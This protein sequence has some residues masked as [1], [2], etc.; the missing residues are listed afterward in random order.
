MQKWMWKQHIHCYYTGHFS[1][2]KCSLKLD[3]LLTCHLHNTAPT[4]LW[5]TIQVIK[6]YQCSYSQRTKLSQA[7]SAGLAASY[8]S[9]AHPSDCLSS[10]RCQRSTVCR[11]VKSCKLLKLCWVHGSRFPASNECWVPGTNGTAM[12]DRCTS[13]HK[14]DP[15]KKDKGLPCWKNMNVYNLPVSY[16]LQDYCVS[17]WNFER[18]ACTLKYVSF[19]P[20]R[21]EKFKNITFKNI[22]PTSLF[23]T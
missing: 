22:C 7:P 9:G 11:Q 21:V 15:K 10:K 12:Q 3:T 2:D 18:M 6:T 16:W 4:S 19:Y 14:N 13:R 8:F 5:V 1:F 17:G 20:G 23:D